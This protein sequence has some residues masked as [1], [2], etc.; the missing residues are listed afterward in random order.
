MAF[1]KFL[2]LILSF[3]L[4]SCQSSS[5]EILPQNQVIAKFTPELTFDWDLRSD[6]PTNSQYSSEVVDIDAFDNSAALVAKLQEQGKKV[7]AYIS[8]GSV[9]SWRADASD[10]PA[11]IIGNNYDG[12][13]GEKFLD[14][15]RIDLLAPIMRAR[16]DMIKAKGFDAV[17][18]D[19][20]DSYTNNTGFDI[21]EQDVINYCKWLAEEAHSRG[22]SIGQKN[23]SE[24]AP[25][26]VG[27]FDWIL[28]EG[29][30]QEGIE[31]EAKVY[32]T[33]NKAV[34]ATEY[35]DVMTVSE[36]QN[37]V[38]PKAATLRYSAIFKHRELDGYQVTCN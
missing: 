13:D 6:L 15:R 3:F 32:I 7:I 9:E 29:A 30:F 34:F 5:D 11:S 2:L 20:I 26:L 1:H 17:E 4:F 31:D 12:W 38:C 37:T 24:L 19:N 23:A 28:L 8:V 36:F 21:T 25:Q 16:L 35:D 22:L 10:F 27:T 14:I 18:P 33:N